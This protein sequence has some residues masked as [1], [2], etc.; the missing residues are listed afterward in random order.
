MSYH[1]SLCVSLTKPKY[2]SAKKQKPTVATGLHSDWRD[3]APEKSQ[4]ERRGNSATHDADNEL[5]G[6]VDADVEA[7]P[8]LANTD[9]DNDNR[10]GETVIIY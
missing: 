10:V 1:L 4:R 8:P 9:Q 7:D 6:F 3:R 5:G 2:N